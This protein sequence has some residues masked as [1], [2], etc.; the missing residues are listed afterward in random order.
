MN[1][2]GDQAA[3]DVTRAAAMARRRLDGYLAQWEQTA[4]KLRRSEYRADDLV[5]DCFRVWGNSLRDAWAL[6]AVLSRLAA[7]PSRS[8]SRLR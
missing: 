2:G 8:R 3:D 4:A 6:A 7:D 1:R 5:E